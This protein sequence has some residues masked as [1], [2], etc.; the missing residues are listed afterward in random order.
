MRKEEKKQGI[1]KFLKL[2]SWIL[3]RGIP[4]R[5]FLHE[6]LSEVVLLGGTLRSKR[7]QR[8]ARQKEADTSRICEFL[9]MN[10]PSFTG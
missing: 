8:G 10:F 4:T 1:V 6:E 7:E 5:S 3:S 9:R 2:R